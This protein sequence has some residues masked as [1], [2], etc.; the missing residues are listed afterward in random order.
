[1]AFRRQTKTTLLTD[2]E[3]ADPVQ[4]VGV[5]WEHVVASNDNVRIPERPLKITDVLVQENIDPLDMITETFVR[6]VNPRSIDEK[7]GGQTERTSSD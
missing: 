5:N 2:E 6:E 7:T 4:D 3:L 1:M